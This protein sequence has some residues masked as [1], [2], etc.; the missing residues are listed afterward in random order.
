MMRREQRIDRAELERLR[1]E[2]PGARDTTGFEVR[3]RCQI[4]RLD[5]VPLQQFGLGALEDLLDAFV[6]IEQRQA[7]CSMERPGARARGDVEGRAHPARLVLV[8]ARCVR[9]GDEEDQLGI[10]LGRERAFAPVEHRGR[11][12]A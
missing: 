6:A 7:P 3:P 9:V 11:V 10:E 2:L 12:T 5:V 4:V 8:S 1:H